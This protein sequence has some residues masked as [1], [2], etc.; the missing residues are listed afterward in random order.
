MFDPICGGPSDDSIDFRV[1]HQS[2]VHVTSV[3]NASQA[4]WY[5]VFLSMSLMSDV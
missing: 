2:F 4:P 1:G 5:L 3:P